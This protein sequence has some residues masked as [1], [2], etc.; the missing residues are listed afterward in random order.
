M[1]S[2]S[3]GQKFWISRVYVRH[4][5]KTHRYKCLDESVKLG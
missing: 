4:V 2:L 3:I 5:S 1:D